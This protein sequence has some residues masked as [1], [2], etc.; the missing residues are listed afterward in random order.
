M[1]KQSIEKKN[2]K[3]QLVLFGRGGTKHQKLHLHDAGERKRSLMTKK[4]L[5]SRLICLS[6]PKGEK[7]AEEI[8][9][10]LIQANYRQICRITLS[11]MQNGRYITLSKET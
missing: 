7:T 1:Y 11:I 6:C 8:L 10:I 4:H 9:Y 2:K 5:E 3:H